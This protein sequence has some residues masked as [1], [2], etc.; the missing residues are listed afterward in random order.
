MIAVLAMTGLLQP[1][2][3]RTVL[4][5]H[6]YLYH[7]ALLLIKRRRPLYRHKY[8]MKARNPTGNNYQKKGV[9]SS[10]YGYQGSKRL[11]KLTDL[12]VSWYYNW[13]L[14]FPTKR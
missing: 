7:P 13:E 8:P 2:A 11:D 6:P 14:P 1:Q 12:G 10:R 4:R 9:G 5:H 3:A